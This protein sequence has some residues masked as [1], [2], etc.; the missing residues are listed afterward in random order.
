MV[1][2]RAKISTCEHFEMSNFGPYIFCKHCIETNQNTNN[3]PAVINIFR[4]YFI[5]F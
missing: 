3:N 4:S 5:T 1:K 2:K